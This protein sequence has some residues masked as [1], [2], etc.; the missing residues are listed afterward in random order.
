MD[1]EQMTKIANDVENL[2]ASL[3]NLTSILSLLAEV[4]CNRKDDQIR[5]AFFLLAD[6]SKRFE[7]EAYR[8]WG[9]LR[10]EKDYVSNRTSLCTPANK[11]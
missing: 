5:A 7:D 8:I 10:E 2:G 6:C 1:K 9:I 4:N 3:Y 11:G